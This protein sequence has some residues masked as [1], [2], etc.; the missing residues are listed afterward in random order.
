MQSFYKTEKI[1]IDGVEI[2]IR[3]LSA[4]DFQDFNSLPPVEKAATMCSRCVLEWK[5]ETAE[6]INDNVPV[7]LLV[8]IMQAL[9]KLS[10]LDEPKNSEPT[11]S[12]DSSS[13]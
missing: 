6:S 5:G 4:K 7:R 12:A 11:P 10:G 8:E 1:K 3:E 13:G 2:T 9:F